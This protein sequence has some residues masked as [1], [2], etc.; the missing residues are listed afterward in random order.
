MNKKIAIFIFHPV[1]KYNNNYFFKEHH[2]IFIEEISKKYKSVFVLSKLIYGRKIPSW[3]YDNS[4][5]IYKY[6]FINSNIKYIKSRFLSFF[7]PLF[8]LYSVIMADEVLFFMPSISFLIFAPILNFFK[9]PY[10]AYIASDIYAFKQKSKKYYYYLKLNKKYLS[11]ANG[12]LCRGKKNYDSV[13]NSKKIIINSFLILNGQEVNITLKEKLILYVGVID[14]NKNIDK[15]IESYCHIY[16]HDSSYS[17]SIIGPCSDENK[18]YLEELKKINI[19]LVNKGKILFHGPIYDKKILA[20]YY[21]KAKYLVNVSSFE[22]FPKVI[23][24]S[25][26]YEVV[27]ILSNS[28]NYKNILEENKNYLLVDD[29]NIVESITQIVLNTPDSTLDYI[30]KYNLKYIKNINHEPP[31]EKFINLTLEKQ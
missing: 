9:K 10:Y 15:I 6:T 21:A 4:G 14:P 3:M 7:Y 31:Y 29:T 2:G 16:K 25:M 18:K 17:L 12:V 11:L 13:E 27:P 30:K 23:H 8:Y 20:S 24:E 26:L 5:I 1:V 22:G 19:D 28:S